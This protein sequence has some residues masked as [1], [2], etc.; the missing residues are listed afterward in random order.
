MGL[1]RSGT[2]NGPHSRGPF[3]GTKT[4]IPADP[5]RGQGAVRT[6]E[7][8]APAGPRRLQGL[9]SPWGPRLVDSLCHEKSNDFLNPVGWG[10][11]IN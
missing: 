5:S 10:E 7:L 11:G 1:I 2:Q 3:I 8:S 6:P 4:E 9:P